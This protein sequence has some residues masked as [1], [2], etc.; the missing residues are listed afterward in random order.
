MTR[1]LPAAALLAAAL[2]LPAAVAAHGAAA[3]ADHGT[4]AGHGT[5]ASA[6]RAPR[7]QTDWGVPGDPRAATRT[8]RVDMDDTMRFTPDRL[9]VRAGETVRIVVRNR[10]RVMHELVLGSDAALA[11]HAQQMRQDPSMPHDEPWMAHVAPGATGEL[12]WTFNRSGE[13]A[14]A[15][16]VP[17]H[18]EAG[19]TGRVVVATR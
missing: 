17:G 9:T 7:V 8:V 6:K 3:P 4:H 16:L 5:P 13:F 19:M 10:G 18:S 15:C 12:T 2:L 1:S 14:F 11:R